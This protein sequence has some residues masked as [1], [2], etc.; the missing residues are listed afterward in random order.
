[1]DKNGILTEL[2][3]SKEI[4]SVIQ[5]FDP[6]ELRDDLKSELFMV[7]VEIEESQL[8]DMYNRKVLKFFMVRTILN[9][10]KSDRS[11][12]YNRYRNFVEFDANAYNIKALINETQDDH[13]TI[14]KLTQNLE[15]IH[16]YNAEILKLYAIE[17]GFNAKEISRQTGIPYISIIRTLQKTKKDL[18]KKLKK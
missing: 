4:D 15:E 3:K 17:T 9:M 13:E 10:I 14:D 6:I 12:F 11:T 2:W 18:K 1:M 5:K 8:I 16:W 7:L